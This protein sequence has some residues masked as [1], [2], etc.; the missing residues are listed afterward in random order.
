MHEESDSVEEKD[1]GRG[2]VF[3][4]CSHRLHVRQIDQENWREM[5]L[6]FISCVEISSS[7]VSLET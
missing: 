3:E 6:P 5:F 2:R 1:L 4:S 7:V